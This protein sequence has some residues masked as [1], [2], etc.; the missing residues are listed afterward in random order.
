[1]KGE[2]RDRT[3][4][5]R[6]AEKSADEWIGQYTWTQQAGIPADMNRILRA[7]WI[8]GYMAALATTEPQGDSNG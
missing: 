2:P 6:R 8:H 1:M 3:A 7:M 4:D 5:Y